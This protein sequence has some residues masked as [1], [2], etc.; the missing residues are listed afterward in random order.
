MRPCG[1]DYTLHASTPDQIYHPPDP[2]GPRI[3]SSRPGRARPDTRFRI[4]RPCPP[5]SG[6]R[7]RQQR[8]CHSSPSI[9]SPL[10]KLWLRS[11]PPLPLLAVPLVPVT[12]VVLVEV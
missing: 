4:S 10:P 11:L 9:F 2:E 7:V 6:P 1:G 3:A 12:Y 8:S 5:R